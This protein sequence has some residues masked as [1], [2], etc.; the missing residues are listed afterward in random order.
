MGHLRRQSITQQ[1]LA[2]YGGGGG[3]GGDPHFASVVALLHCDGVDGSTTFTDVTG[4]SWTGSGNAQIDTAQS[5]F[6]GAS[7]L[8]DGTGDFISTADAAAL[9]IGASD[10]T[11]ETWV[12]FNAFPAAGTVATIFSKFSGTT[13]AWRMGVFNNAGTMRLL[14]NGDDNNTAGQ[15]VEVISNW[16]ASLNTWYHLESDRT[17]GATYLFVD[18]NLL[19]SG[20]D[21]ITYFNNANPLRIGSGTGASNFLNGW[22]DDI[23]LTVGVARHTS[24]FTPPSAPHPDS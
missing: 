2:S 17:G 5:K 22:L 11:A 20:A 24:N 7:L 8:L 6:G 18:G 12:R 3:G 16:A 13:Y 1:L 19:V 4:R 23:R 21:N 10:F 9:D 15:A 14:W